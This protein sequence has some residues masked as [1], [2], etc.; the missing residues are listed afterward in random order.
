MDRIKWEESASASRMHSNIKLYGVSEDKAF[1][2]LFT[3]LD[4]LFPEM[5]Y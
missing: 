2:K 1:V 4:E 3:G 5:I